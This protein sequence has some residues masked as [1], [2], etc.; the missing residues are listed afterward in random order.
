MTRCEFVG[1]DGKR[2]S[3]KAV[4]KVRGK[5]LCQKHFSRACEQIYREQ[6]NKPLEV[7]Q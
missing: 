2:C 4:S 6:K 1:M 5:P 3:R 7:K